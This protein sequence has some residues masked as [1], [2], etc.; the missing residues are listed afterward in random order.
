MND[1]TP[2]V[3]RTGDALIVVD[4]QED[5]LPG[6]SL[7]VPHGN[8]VV[9]VLNDYIQRFESRSLPVIA[10]RDWHPPDHCSFVAQGGTWP[11]H[12][13]A[14]TPAAGFAP[15]LHLPEAVTVISKGTSAGR[16]A[17]SGFQD[18]NL[19]PLL[20]ERGVQRVF[21]G[22]LA[23]DYCVLN[24]VRDACDQGFEVV[25]LGDAIRP[26]DVEPGDGER[27]VAEMIALGARPIRLAELS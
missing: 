21:V 20:R 12:C 10:T 11:P 22:G 25:L 4:V 5:F 23:T 14:G 18:T 13:V 7:A 2:T 16:D 3:P 19:G 15:E 1:P 27:A 8:E 6:G 26:V 9:P 17:Y 24:T